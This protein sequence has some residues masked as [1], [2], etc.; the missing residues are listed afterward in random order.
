MLEGNLA[1]G[2]WSEPEL[3]LELTAWIEAAAEEF[4]GRGLLG[5]QGAWHYSLP[6]AVELATCRRGPQYPGVR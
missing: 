4:E 2:F 6:L 5:L 3:A 1:L